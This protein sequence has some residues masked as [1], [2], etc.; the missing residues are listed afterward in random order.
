MVLEVYGHPKAQR[1]YAWSS[2]AHNEESEYIVV[3]EIPPVD[4]PEA[5]VQ[6]ALA[7]RIV[8][9]RSTQLTIKSWFDEAEISLD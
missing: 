4:S 5:A 2:R 1:A 6:A 3:L 9:G 7:A 8:T